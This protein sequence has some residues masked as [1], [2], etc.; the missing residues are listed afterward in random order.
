MRRSIITNA[1]LIFTASAILS[2]TGC[3]NNVE[4]IDFNQKATEYVKCFGD[5]ISENIDPEQTW[6]TSTSTTINVNS[7]K[8][9]TFKVFA[10]SGFGKKAAALLTEK[11]TAGITHTFTI[12]R[13]QDSNTLYAALTDEDGFF[14]QFS[15]NAD[16]NVTLNFK[17]DDT[18]NMAKGYKESVFGNFVMPELK[19]TNTSINF[20]DEIDG[21]KSALPANCEEINDYGKN[22][23]GNYYVATTTTAINAWSG[24]CDIYFPSGTYNIT[25]L[26]MGSNNDTH[27]VYLLPG[28][29]VTMPLTAS[30][31]NQI[32]V[33]EGATLN[34]SGDM[35]TSWS[36]Y[37]RG[38]VNFTNN[39][40][41]SFN[42][43]KKAV[44]FNRG[45]MNVQGK[46]ETASNDNVQF[47][48]RGT[49]IIS[50]DAVVASNWFSS[51]TLTVKGNGNVWSDKANLIL[52]GP[53]TFEKKLTVNGNVVSRTQIDVTGDLCISGNNGRFTNEATA[54][55]GS[56][57]EC[58]YL[59]NEGG[60]MKVKGTTKLD[61][62]HTEWINNATYHTGSWSLTNGG[63]TVVNRCKLVVD[64]LL[65]HDT[66]T[67]NGGLRI[68]GGASV[69]TKDAYS[70]NGAIELGKKS[71]FKVTGTLTMHNC[72]PTNG[73]KAKGNGNGWG[74]AAVLQANRI[75][76]KVDKQY[77]AACY[78]GNMI[79]A[80][81][82]HF[83]NDQ[84][85]NYYSLM[86]GA[87]MV[88]TDHNKVTK[89]ET[90]TCNPGYPLYDDNGF[91]HPSDEDQEM[92]Y[93]YAFEDLGGIG[94]FDFNDIVIR[95]SAVKYGYITI[96]LC[97][98][99][100]TYSTSINLGEQE[101]CHEVHKAFG[102][103]TSTMVNTLSRN[104]KPF[105][106]LGSWAGYPDPANLP[107]SITL[108]NGYVS[109]TISAQNEKGKAP[110]SIVVHG[111]PDNGTWDWPDEWQ[112]IDKTFEGF[113]YWVQDRNHFVNWWEK[114]A[115][116]M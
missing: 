65:T 38:T 58:S 32:F 84:K 63:K 10:K 30:D 62:N 26:Y 34:V 56:V 16:E 95:A 54:N 18:A 53:T 107:I 81:N 17:D 11:V 29:N 77:N 46:L 71:L 1:S 68:E 64:T 94:D 79:V 37:N 9:G 76:S 105:V 90:T 35:S 103:D 33:A 51:G 19:F 20:A 22:K 42:N 31:N 106:T 4:F 6:N 78:S 73:F 69:I 39:A 113:N 88:D 40:Y 52:E 109:K 2:F 28:A 7:E 3:S 45:T 85:Q 80:T 87:K 50:G 102:V 110:L 36:I 99:G 49:T 41:L 59:C 97:A 44:I 23:G 61:K 108:E 116:H 66:S 48:N 101:I 60:V 112:R 67:Q 21:Y 92:W 86:Y 93:Y 74:A 111:S 70:G 83:V 57:S 115:R 14:T 114:Q 72:N 5:S 24:N 47:I 75:V 55:A 43:N 27:Y 98:A 89:I 104:E 82:D 25:S 96:E 13:P 100:G 12:A 8:A 15:F 91:E